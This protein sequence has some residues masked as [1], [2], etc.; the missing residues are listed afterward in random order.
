MSEKEILLYD[1]V[2]GF[3]QGKKLKNTYKYDSNQGKRN[4]VVNNLIDNSRVLNNNKI[5]YIIEEE[6]E[7]KIPLIKHIECNN[8]N[9]NEYINV[10]IKLKRKT[11]IN[12]L[13]CVIIKHENG[14][15]TDKELEEIIINYSEEYLSKQQ[16]ILYNL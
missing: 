7:E 15:F 4:Q 5:N 12:F 2:I 11:I 14:D 10:K 6:I 3:K 9:E 16:H 1:D 8:Y 13:N